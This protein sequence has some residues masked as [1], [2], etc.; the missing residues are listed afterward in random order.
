[1]KRHKR[2]TELTAYLLN[3][4]NEWEAFCKAHKPFAEKLKQILSENAC[5]KNEVEFFKSENAC[6]RNEV[7]RLRREMEE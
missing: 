6:L 2:E 3:V 4:L 5:L 1:M 7:E